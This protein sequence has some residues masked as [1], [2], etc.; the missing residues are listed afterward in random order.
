[1]SGS[2][3]GEWSDGGERGTNVESVGMHG[4]EVGGDVYYERRKT[5]DQF[6][7][8]HW[9][10]VRSPQ[11]FCIRPC[12]VGH[13]QILLLL[14]SLWYGMVAYFPFSE[15][16][17]DPALI[18]FIH[19]RHHSSSAISIVLPAAPYGH[20]GRD[21]DTQRVLFCG[22]HCACPSSPSRKS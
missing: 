11:Y 18:Q 10:G 7:E 19:I 1:M 16:I 14:Y 20:E 21:G 17:L 9:Y 5:T 15:T 6:M 12:R 13:P 2:E 22:S 8:R 4:S 3:Q